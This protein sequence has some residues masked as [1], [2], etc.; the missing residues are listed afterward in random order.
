VKGLR[1]GVDVGG[2]FTDLV[3]DDG[4]DLTIA[5]VPSTPGDQAEGVLAGL[6]RLSVD[7]SSVTRFV[8]GTTVATN[9]ILE[10]RGARTVLVTTRGFRDLL[11]IGRQNR[12]KL[13]DLFADR[14]APVVPRELVVEAS[15]RVGAGGEVLQALGDPSSVAEAVRRLSPEAVAVC[16]LFSFLRPEHERAIRQALDGTSVSLSSEV[17]PVFR[18]YERASTTCLN[19]YVQPILSRY[20]DSLAG[21]L[22]SMGMPCEVEVMRSGGGTF[23]A[24]LAARL[25]VHTLLSGPA[26]GAWGAA[27]VGV[28]AGFPDLIAFDMGG[29]STDTSL[30]EGGRPR[31]TGE[32]SIAGLPFSVTSTEIHTVG[33]GGGSIAW[34][35]SGGALRVGPRS[36]GADPGP[37]CYGRGGED[38][39]VTDAYLLLGLLDPSSP[40]GGVLALERRPAERAVGRLAQELGMGIS[41]C[42]QGIL[43]V[44]EAQVAKALRVVSVER[45]QDPRRH[46]LLAF[47]GAGPLHQGPLGRDL[48]CSA[49]IVPRYPGVLA[50]LGLLAAPSAV[51]IV[52]TRLRDVETVDTEELES[53]WRELEDEARRLLSRQGTEPAVVAWTADCRYR[54]QAHELEV[55]PVDPSPSSLTAAF[56]RTHRERYGYVHGGEQVEVVNLR[57]R[58]EG[59]APRFPL[60][61]LSPGRGVED[62]L[63][64]RR[65]M[66]VEGREEDCAVYRREALG[67]EDRLSGPALVT[68]VDATCLILRGQKAEVDGWGNLVIR[69]A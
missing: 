6:G 56:E 61:E 21:R 63:S 66:A 25:A 2:T 41:E 54:G 67:P 27:A 49:V 59:P 39:A 22:R 26:A 9:A 32:G 7:S 20:L 47:G 33:A 8:H 5:K 24:E 12:P 69:E 51:D 52:A 53:S 29:T 28:R 3:L 35:D 4:E 57:V 1:L 19:A 36:A 40:L 14:P 58:A 62:A 34:S 44:T 42:A 16:L 31:T 18:E 46:A 68:A 30:I 60:P 37:A 55:R 11:E 23:A 13:Y 10:R 43:K 15:E 50:A 45:G 17:L 64:G 48:G 38:P 65:R